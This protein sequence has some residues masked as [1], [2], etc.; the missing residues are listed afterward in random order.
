VR[1]FGK[2][3][4]GSWICQLSAEEINRLLRREGA[5]KNRAQS[6]A[7][8]SAILKDIERTYGLPDGSVCV[9]NPETKKPYRRDA[10]IKTIRR[11]SE[12]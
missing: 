6:I 4:D 11:K 12:D 1:K 8:L 7:S 2:L 10:L 3:D 9:I 5:R